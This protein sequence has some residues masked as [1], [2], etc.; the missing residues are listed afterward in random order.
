MEPTPILQLVDLPILQVLNK[1]TPK[2]RVNV[3]Q[4]HENWLRL[5]VEVN[6]PITKLVVVV[7][8][9]SNSENFFST[10]LNNAVFG[11]NGSYAQRMTN[12]NEL[13]KCSAV[14]QYFSAKKHEVQLTF[15][16]VQHIVTAFPNIEEL[17]FVN[18]SNDGTRYLLEMLGNVNWNQQLH[19]LQLIEFSESYT[20]ARTS[21]KLFNII[22]HH[23]PVL[24][25]LAIVSYS[26]EGV[27]IFELPVLS[28]LQK[29]RVKHY[30]DEHIDTFLKSVVKYAPANNDHLLID[31]P[32]ALEIIFNESFGRC[33][34]EITDLIFDVSRTFQLAQVTDNFLIENLPM[35]DFVC[36]TFPRLTSISFNC[37][38]ITELG[39]MLELIAVHLQHVSHLMIKLK[40]KTLDL[41]L[42]AEFPVVLLP[43]VTAV[44]FDLEIDSHI[45]VN[46]LLGWLNLPVILPNLQHIHLINYKCAIC[47]IWFSQLN[48]SFENEFLRS[49]E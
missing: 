22:N 15:T 9:D 37:T 14:I 16:N 11:F 35:M 32:G 45:D 31:L 30:K 2:D 4:M 29:V 39:P 8:D 6:N 18:N 24:A 49:T 26:T 12:Q 43:T 21:A 41:L 10:S 36:L 17:T 3:S 34:S 47:E 27:K 38:S 25:N 5:V 42:N 46:N 13:P 19:T 33:D 7:R 20:S 48:T 44:E 23:L 1:I 40:L 28:K